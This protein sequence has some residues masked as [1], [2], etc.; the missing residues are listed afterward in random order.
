MARYLLKF[1]LYSPDAREG[2]VEACSGRDPGVGLRFF[3]G[4]GRPE[5]ISLE[6]TKEKISHGQIVVIFSFGSHGFTTVHSRN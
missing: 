3:R 6:S 1:A 2:V 5:E 4:S